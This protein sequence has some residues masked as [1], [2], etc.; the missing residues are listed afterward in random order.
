MTAHKKNDTDFEKGAS[1][2]PLT[3]RAP[4]EEELNDEQVMDNREQKF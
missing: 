4:G 3:D 2:G 1:D